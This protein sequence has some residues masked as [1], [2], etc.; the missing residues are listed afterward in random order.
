[1]AFMPLSNGSG[2]DEEDLITDFTTLDHET[3]SFTAA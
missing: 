3:K 1:M 2:L